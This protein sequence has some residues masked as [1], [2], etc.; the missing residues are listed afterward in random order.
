MQLLLKQLSRLLGVTDAQITLAGRAAGAI[1]SETW[2][3][4]GDANPTDAA[5]RAAIIAGSGGITSAAQFELSAY[6][7]EDTVCLISY[8]ADTIAWTTG[9]TCSVYTRSLEIIVDLDCGPYATDA[10]RDAKRAE[11][12]AELQ[13]A[14]PELSVT[15]DTTELHLLIFTECRNVS[16]ELRLLS[17]CAKI[18][19]LQTQFSLTC[20]RT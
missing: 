2:I 17:L 18:V 20:Q 16:S 19:K 4:V 9:K 1:D 7:A 8:S 10:A 12:L 6:A 14:F 15:A 5:L 13:A 11:K 3:I